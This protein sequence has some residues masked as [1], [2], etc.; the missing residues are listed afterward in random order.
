M[1]YLII[2]GILTLEASGIKLLLLVIADA[3]I[4]ED[5]VILAKDDKSVVADGKSDIE[6]VNV[7]EGSML[8]T[9]SVREDVAEATAALA[10][11]LG[12]TEEGSAD[13]ALNVLVSKVEVVGRSDEDDI[14]NM[15]LANAASDGLAEVATREE[16]I[17]VMMLSL[18]MEVADDKS[19]VDEVGRRVA[20]AVLDSSS[21]VAA[22]D[23]D[24]ATA[25]SLVLTGREGVADAADDVE[26][27]FELVGTTI[28]V[29]ESVVEVAIALSVVERTAVSVVEAM[30]LS[31][32]DIN[33]LSVLLDGS[34]LCVVEGSALS[35][36]EGSTLSVV[37]AMMLSDVDVTM[38]SDED[39]TMLSVVG[40]M[41]L[42]V[43][44]T[45][46]LSVVDVMAPS[47]VGPMV[48]LVVGTITLSVVDAMILSLVGIALLSV[49][50]T[51]TPV[52]VL[53]TALLSV[54]V[55]TILS[56]G[57]R[58]LLSVVAG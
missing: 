44:D 37:E 2:L 55:G 47:L 49:V 3:R 31:V 6:S 45:I 10:V 18:E 17:S 1:P 38:L 34:M 53:D 58:V 30:L 29:L 50:E 43:V 54:V 32:L 41:M 7:E 27:V 28:A 19:S 48:L 21:V 36:V 23:D 20:A 25:V 46:A 57:D 40:A 39:V 56:V 16:E 11:I 42:L 33:A 22:T 24:A 12:S 35:V 51:I 52:S 8:D 4:D 26:A 5:E 9:S 15:E 13:V 14:T